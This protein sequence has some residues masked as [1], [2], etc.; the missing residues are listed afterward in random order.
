MGCKGSKPGANDPMPLKRKL[1]AQQVAGHA[2]NMDFQED[3]VIKT[4]KPGEKLTYKRLDSFGVR[5]FAP[6][7][8]ALN[9]NT[10]EIENLMQGCDTEQLRLIDLKLGTSTLTMQKK[11]NAEA[12]ADKLK[13]DAETTTQSHGFCI[14]GYKTADE[15]VVK[16]IIGADTVKAELTKVIHGPGKAEVI[17]WMKKFLDF[18]KNENKRQIRGSSLLIVLDDTKSIYRVRLI[19]LVSFDELPEGERDEGMIFGVENL[20]KILE[21]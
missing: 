18:L 5:K 1:T 7:L 21:E 6:K 14:C 2:G 17:E 4:V 15:T 12:I 10:I 3:R 20:L 11:D 8:L 16:P 19:D 9:E 13:K